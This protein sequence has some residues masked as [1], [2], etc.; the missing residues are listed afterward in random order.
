MDK[1]SIKFLA[2][3]PEFLEGAVVC[4]PVDG[5]ESFCFVS[6]IVVGWQDEMR[7]CEDGLHRSGW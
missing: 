1:C 3:E 6:G 4:F 5:V 2:C 7:P